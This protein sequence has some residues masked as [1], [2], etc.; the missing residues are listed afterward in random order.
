MVLEQTQGALAL[1]EA[2]A[3]RHHWIIEPANGRRSRGECR[4][5]REVR[6]FENSIYY[7]AD[8]EE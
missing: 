1:E 6:D 8:D 7:G 3:C 2:P 5:C 4:N